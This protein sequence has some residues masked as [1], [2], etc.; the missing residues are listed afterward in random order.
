MN[1]VIGKSK[2]LFLLRNGNC[3]IGKSL[4]LFLPIAIGIRNSYFIIGTDVQ[5]LMLRCNEC[6]QRMPRNFVVGTLNYVIGKSEILFLLRNGNCVIGKSEI[7]F[8][9][10]NGNCVIGKSEILFLLHNGNCV[11]GKSKTFAV[12][13]R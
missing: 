3:V 13:I 7:L 9:L 2:I 4:I 1:Y 8:L 6:F 5:A 12:G 10:R 11:I